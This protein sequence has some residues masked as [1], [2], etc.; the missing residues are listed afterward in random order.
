M[1]RAHSSVEIGS[2][3]VFVCAS[4]RPASDLISTAFIPLSVASVPRI[5]GFAKIRF[6][7]GRMRAAV[8]S[9]LIVRGLGNFR[10]VGVAGDGASVG[11]W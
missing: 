3:S 4:R 9:G 10:R 7:A 11:S 8:A 6:V 5:I 2:A 1:H